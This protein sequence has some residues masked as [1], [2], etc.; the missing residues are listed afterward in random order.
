MTGI[1][2]NVSAKAI[3]EACCAISVL[4]VNLTS[5]T[6]GQ[7]ERNFQTVA[8]S[9]IDTTS[10]TSK[11]AVTKIGTGYKLLGVVRVVVIQATI[12]HTPH[13]LMFLSIHA[14]GTWIYS[15][16]HIAQQQ[17]KSHIASKT[18]QDALHDLSFL[19]GIER[20]SILWGDDTR[21]PKDSSYI[22]F[23]ILINAV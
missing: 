16:S 18:K 22:H 4:A 14:Q 12:A 2:G 20:A 11:T 1:Q 7:V 15:L 13:P 23:V 19:P 8:K 9:D 17:I 10:A 5:F 6:G 21:L 3:N